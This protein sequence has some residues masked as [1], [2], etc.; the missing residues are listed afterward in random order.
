MNFHLIIFPEQYGAIARTCYKNGTIKGLIAT[1][2]CQ[3]WTKGF[4]STFCFCDTDLCD[5]SAMPTSSIPLMVTMVTMWTIF[6]TPFGLFLF[7][8]NAYADYSIVMC[9]ES[10][11]KT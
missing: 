7:I 1:V 2:G 8:T 11:P 4:V 5:T 10:L 9:V 6:I 3:E